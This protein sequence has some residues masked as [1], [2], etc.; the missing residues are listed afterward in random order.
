MT[1]ESRPLWRVRI[2]RRHP[3][4][5]DAIGWAASARAIV[6]CVSLVRGT[7]SSQIGSVLPS[8]LFVQRQSAMTETSPK[9][10]SVSSVRLSASPPPSYAI[11]QSFASQ[12]PWCFGP[13]RQPLKS[14]P[15]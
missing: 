2:A 7:P 8:L 3:L 13:C 15:E 1:S 10:C 5:D 12:W 14:T 6:A 4:A 11:T 9:A